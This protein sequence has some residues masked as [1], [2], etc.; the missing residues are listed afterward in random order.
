MA[1]GD[2]GSVTVSIGSR[3]LMPQSYKGADALVFGTNGK[4]VGSTD[5]EYS[6]G[7][8]APY[9]S[10]AADRKTS[11]SFLGLQDI[12]LVGDFNYVSGSDR[13][14]STQA[15]GSGNYFIALS[16]DPAANW[17][18][19]LFPSGLPVN[20][21]VSV[22]VHNFDMSLGLEGKTEGWLL[23]G[24]TSITPVFH[25]G[26]LA[27]IQR[28]KVSTRL[29]LVTNSAENDSLLERLQTTDIGPELRVGLA[30]KLPSGLTVSATANAALL[31]GWAD[32]SASQD[33]STTTAS[34]NTSGRSSSFHAT[35]AAS[36][37]FFSG[38]LGL[39]LRAEAPLAEKL[40]LGLDATA[41]YWTRRPTIKNPTTLAGD[42]AI[43]TPTSINK[44]VRIGHDSAAELGAALRFT[45][46]F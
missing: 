38:L 11:L 44:G 14:S 5:T 12:R 41:R 28:Y 19:G 45:Y 13:N 22:A 42:G 34:W 37:S 39:T 7:F 33:L 31:A 24:G 20:T 17:L 3:Y 10:L 6:S 4:I 26:L 23:A 29:A 9:I 25:A 18:G 2:Q 40:K 35:H 36:E 27:S 21:H 30:A 32:L 16:I 8:L 43:T 1:S 46:S 15:A